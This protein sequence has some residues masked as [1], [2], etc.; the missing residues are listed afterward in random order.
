MARRVNG[1]QELVDPVGAP[2]FTLPVSILAQI[3]ESLK[4]DIVAQ[5]IPK[6]QIN[7]ASIA[8]GVVF[9]VAQSGAWTVNA[10]QT[11]AWTVNVQTAAGVSLNVNIASITS[12]VVF[13]VAQSGSWTVNVQTA[14]GVSLNVNIASITSGVVF[15]VAQ[16][17]TW[18]INAAQTGSW[19]INAVQS[20]SWTVNV[21]GSVTISGTPSVNIADAVV[22][23][24]ALKLM[25]SGTIKRI[26]GIVQNGSA[27]MYT[28]P[29]GKKAYIFSAFL[30]AY[31]YAAGEHYAYVSVYDGSYYY[32]LIFLDGPDSV[33]QMNEAIGFTV[34]SIPAGWSLVC[35]ANAYTWGRACCVVVE[36]N[37]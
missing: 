30:D 37:A 9:N 6:L 2:D 29:T 34:M 24:S 35:Y 32:H 4:V 25:D 7:I 27:T 22:N 28:V 11:G 19:T 14:A 18:T 8:S 26:G 10:A 5:T 16:S 15:N 17:G 13:N 12:G 23:I 31:H 20:G 36:A 21:T 3:I 33:D 1:R